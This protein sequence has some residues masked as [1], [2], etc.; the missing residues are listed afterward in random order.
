MVFPEIR[1]HLIRAGWLCAAWR[2]FCASSAGFTKDTA[3]QLRFKCL[4]AFHICRDWYSLIV[5]FLTRFQAKLHR[6]F[7]LFIF[8]Y[9]PKA[10]IVRHTDEIQGLAGWSWTNSALF[11]SIVVLFIHSQINA[12]FLLEG[13][14]FFFWKMGRSKNWMQPYIVAILF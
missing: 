12:W 14:F 9:Y 5:G 3:T 10:L 1:S 2:A 4:K 13:F 11:F 6:Y 7:F 8:F